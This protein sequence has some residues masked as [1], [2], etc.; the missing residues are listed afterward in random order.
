[1]VVWNEVNRVYRYGQ[2]SCCL[3][4]YH[5]VPIEVFVKLS[6]RTEKGR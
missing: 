5:V 6:N 4:M 1:V 3:V 2:N